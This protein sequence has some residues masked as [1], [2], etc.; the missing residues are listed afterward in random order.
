MTISKSIF[1]NYDIRGVYPRD[2]D[3]SS[4]YI[5]GKALGSDFFQRSVKLW[6]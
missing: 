2:F 5:L 6:W 3:D 4:A 1:R